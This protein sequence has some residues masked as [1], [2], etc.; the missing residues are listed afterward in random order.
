M[1]SELLSFRQ[2]EN[3]HSSLVIFSCLC[4]SLRQLARRSRTLL[5]IKHNG[6]IALP[7]FDKIV[8]LS[9]MPTE[10]NTLRTFTISWKMPKNTYLF[11]IGWLLPTFTSS[12]TKE[13]F[14]RWMNLQT[15][16]SFAS[17]KSYKKSPTK[18]LSSISFCINSPKWPSTMTVNMQKSIS[19]NCIRISKLFDIRITSLSL[20]SGVIMRKSFW[21]TRK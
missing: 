19:E 16:S 2:R 15:N 21:L 13:P 7:R 4:S 6:I 12:E 17:I 8:H 18:E 1:N 10:S 9:S 20:F 3:S 14:K 5:L 11:P